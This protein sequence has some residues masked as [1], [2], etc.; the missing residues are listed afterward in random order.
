MIVVVTK[1]K[2]RVSGERNG[3]GTVVV[4]GGMERCGSGIDF[5]FDP[6][7]QPPPPTTTPNPQ[8][9]HIQ[10]FAAIPSARYNFAWVPSVRLSRPFIAPHNLFF[11]R[12][13]LLI[14]L[15]HCFHDLHDFNPHIV[16]GTGDHVSFPI[17]LAAKLKGIKL[18]IHEQNSAPGLAN[19][20]LALVC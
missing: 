18:V 5:Y 13:H 19:S 3:G 4:D 10:N 20:V 11:F 9:H 2:E 16:V 14:S 12:Y 8:A 17:C 1:F 7:P 15:I 6:K